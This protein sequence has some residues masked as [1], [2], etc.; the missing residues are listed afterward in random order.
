M[1]AFLIQAHTDPEHVRRLVERLRPNRV[2]IHLDAKT[3]MDGNWLAIDA[4]F[5][6]PRVPVYWGG[7]SQIEATFAMVR[8]DGPDASGG[9]S[10][11]P[12]GRHLV[13]RPR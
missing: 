9:C 4:T 12:Q 5:V 13:R 11:Q 8:Q 7:Y 2:Y 1:I 3:K 6:T 10:N